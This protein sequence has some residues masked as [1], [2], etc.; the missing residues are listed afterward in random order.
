MQRMMPSSSNIDRDRRNDRRLSGTAYVQAQSEVVMDVDVNDH[1]S[2]SSRIPPSPSKNPEAQAGLRVGA[3]MYADRESGVGDVLPRGPRAMASK[4]PVQ[5]S[6]GEFPPPS[7]LSSPTTPYVYGPNAG[8]RRRDHSP[9]PQQSGYMDERG[10]GYDS[11]RHE[12]SSGW[13]DERHNNGYSMQERSHGHA[14]REPRGRPSEFSRQNLPKLSGTNSVPIGNRKGGLRTPPGGQPPVNRFTSNLNPPPG[15][16]NANMEPLRNPRVR[17][18]PPPEKESYE[19]PPYYAK[20]QVDTY[21]PGRSESVGPYQRRRD[22]SPVV[23]DQRQRQVSSVESPI[24]RARQ[25]SQHVDEKQPNWFDHTI[26]QDSAA[27]RIWIPRQPSPP[28]DITVGRPSLTGASDYRD[29]TPPPISREPSQMS[30]TWESPNHGR[31]SRYPNEDRPQRRL[32][33]SRDVPV[34]TDVRQRQ[35]TNERMGHPEPEVHQPGSLEGRLGDRYDSQDTFVEA[36]RQPHALPP[37]P[38]LHPDHHPITSELRR[39]S[40]LD[41]K[42]SSKQEIFQTGWADATSH[43][44]SSD[45]HDTFDD[46]GPPARD[47]RNPRPPKSF[48]PRRLPSINMSLQD[49]SI[50][51]D[52]DA[53]GFPPEHSQYSQQHPGISR[54][55]GSL[56]DRLSLDHSDDNK[57]I[58][59]PYSSSLRDRVQVPSKRDRD[60]MMGGRYQ[61]E[62]PFGGDDGSFGDTTALKKPRRRNPN[63][64][65]RGAKRGGMA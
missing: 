53:A 27:P 57:S 14:R 10:A 42:G 63:K 9:S 33:N 23:F 16:S 24:I 21:I 44:L 3:G 60:E 46:Q 30:P 29:A 38:T 37:N 65:R 62:N 31:A 43:S 26:T 64:F 36:V 15:I 11:S 28:H 1:P 59:M 12:G 17:G 6:D 54:R 56:L 32:A 13:R 8:G 20:S 52:V 50:S 49:D 22:G 58:G 4:P 2:T 39:K 41:R 5:V 45:V 55:G 48:R 18:A 61:P 40:F 34:N 35:Q 25:E 7:T 51:M 47:M 19:R